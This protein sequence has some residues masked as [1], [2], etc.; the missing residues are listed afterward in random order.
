M[1]DLEGKGAQCLAYRAQL[2]HEHGDTYPG[3]RQFKRSEK[4]PQAT[5][6]SILLL[7][8]HSYVFSSLKN[9]KL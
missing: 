2:E 1:T 8:P 9:N 6:T 5:P 7:K 4:Y 3:T